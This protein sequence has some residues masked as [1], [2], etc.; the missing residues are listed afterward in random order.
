MF[1]A[2]ILRARPNPAT[3]QPLNLGE[4]AEALLFYREVHVTMV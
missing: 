2:L 4:L 1:E 3:A